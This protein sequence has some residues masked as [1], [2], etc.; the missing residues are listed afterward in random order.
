E[1]FITQEYIPFQSARGEHFQMPTRLTEDLAYF[2]GV[3]IGDGHLNY[4]NLE[5]VDFSQENMIM[6]Q[7]LAKVLFGFEGAISG[8]KKIWLLHL[9]NK[10]LVRLVNFLTDQPITGKKY[11]ALREPILFQ[12]DEFLR[13]QFWS[14]ALD[15]DGSYKSTVN[16]CSSSEFF[17]NEFVKVL[18]IYNIKYS[19]RTI[20]TEFGISYAVNIKASSKDLL[21]KFLRPRHPSKQKDFQ[22]YLNKKRRHIID[23]PIK[24]QINRFNPESILAFNNAHYFNFTLLPNLNVINCTSLL[25]SVRK[26][27]SWTQQDLADY[28]SISKEKL[29]SYEYR[30]SLPLQLLE[31]LLPKLPNAPNKV[32]PLLVE[33][34]LDLFRSRKTT[35]RL[36]LQP[37]PTLLALVKNL[38]IR[39]RYL[40]IEK[41]ENSENDLYK[42]LNDYFSIKVTNNQIQNSVLYQYI[43]TFFQTNKEAKTI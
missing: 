13:W 17:I 7:A 20:N 15:A 34:K 16:F 36:D 29:T 24:Y 18:N 3:V 23:D 43:T 8:E 21:G 6:L 27:W 2:L 40:L 25:R 32:M 9:N 39:K 22:H 35:A 5:L 41:S 19:T 1:E 33:N 38:S 26:I 12:N 11:H 37:N 42:S 4:H 14:G 31:K 28:L 30:N 10:W